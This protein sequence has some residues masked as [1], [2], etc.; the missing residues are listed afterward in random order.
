MKRLW[1]GLMSIVL[2]GSLM[3]CGGGDDHSHGHRRPLGVAGIMEGI[4]N[5]NLHSNVTGRDT[6]M[7]VI[8]TA[9]GT[10]NLITDD[11]GQITASITANGSFFSGAGTSYTQTNCDGIDVIVV[12]PSVSGGPVQSFQIAGQFDDRTGAAIASYTTSHDSGTIS[13]I[14]FYPDY[15]HEQGVLPRAGGAYSI[16]PSLTALSVD[17]NNGNVVFRDASGQTFAGT[18]FVLDSSVDVYG[19]TLQVRGQALTGLATL[20]DDGDGRNNDFI[21]AVANGALAYN[22]E[23]KRN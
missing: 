14:N 12:P 18:L 21:F 3:A 1:V 7:F 5:G 11:C 9:G 15:F 17:G 22:A 8:V 2:L 20:V 10:L 16:K 4:W 6:G 13:F 19:M 23:L